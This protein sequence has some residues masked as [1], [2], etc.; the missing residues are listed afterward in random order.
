MERRQRK[1]NKVGRKFT[2]SV[3]GRYY[4]ILSS[5]PHFFL[6]KEKENKTLIMVKVGR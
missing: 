6:T 3:W 1:K 5:D 4:I 2:E